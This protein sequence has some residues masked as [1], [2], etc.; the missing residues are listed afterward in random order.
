MAPAL[1]LGLVTVLGEALE[2][3]CGQLSCGV[4]LSGELLADERVSG[5]PPLKRS[6][7]GQAIAEK[8]M[9]PA[10]GG[11]LRPVEVVFRGAQKHRQSIQRIGPG[12]K[13]P[14]RVCLAPFHLSLR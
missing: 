8:E 1:D 4:A 6:R 14:I 3:F 2:V 11:A 12:P 10:R 13:T 7:G 5:H 9:A